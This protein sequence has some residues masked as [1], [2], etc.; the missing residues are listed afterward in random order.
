MPWEHVPPESILDCNT[1]RLPSQEAPQVATSTHIYM[2]SLQALQKQ[3]LTRALRSRECGVDLAEREYLDGMDFIL[4]PHTGVLLVSLFL[5]PSQC[6]DLV[7]CITA[8]SWRFSRIL[9]ASAERWSDPSAYTP[10]IVK[11]LSKVRRGLD[12]A[13]ACGEKRGGT[14]NY[15]FANNVHEAAALVR[16]YGELAE[17]ASF[18]RVLWGAR[19]WLDEK[20]EAEDELVEVNAM[21]RFSAAVVLA[22]VSAEELMGM[23]PEALV[24]M[25]GPLIGHDVVDTFNSETDPRPPSDG[26]DMLVADDA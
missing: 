21:N 23:S 18:A 5:L 12:I 2:V 20:N 13:E 14:V 25:F 6:A 15:A 19:G 3:A 8:Q 17:A 1:L 11:A 4:D 9:G 10:P 7:A 24:D 26:A 22:R 16:Y